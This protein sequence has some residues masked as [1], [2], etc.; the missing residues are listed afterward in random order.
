MDQPNSGETVDSPDYSNRYPSLEE[1]LPNGGLP[2]QEFAIVSAS[3]RVLFQRHEWKPAKGVSDFIIKGPKGEASASLMVKGDPIYGANPNCG[4]R[5]CSISKS[6]DKETG[7]SPK[8]DKFAKTT[9]PLKQ[10][11]AGA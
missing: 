11:P 2:G 5:L 7:I 1:L 4:L 9:A 6:L 10:E 8:T 3:E